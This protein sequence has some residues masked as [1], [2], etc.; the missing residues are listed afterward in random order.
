M[1]IFDLH[2]DLEVYF[3]I[4]EFLDMPIKDIK[5]LDLRRHGDIPQF[6]KS[7]L[8][9]AV[10]NIFPFVYQNTH[11]K[12]IDYKK[13]LKF[14]ENF[15]EWIFSY[16][17]F[18]PVLSKKDLLEINKEKD[19]IGIILGVEGLNFLD[20]VK[21][22]KDL[23]DLGIRCFGL[24]WNIDSI[25][26]TSLKT[27]KRFGLTPE[28]I[29]LIK[30]LEE[31]NVVIDLAHSSIFTIRDIFK[32]YPKPVIFSHNGVKKIVNFEQNLSTEIINKIRQK[33]GLIGLTLLPYSLSQN[34]QKLD[35]KRFK[36]QYDYLSKIISANIS[37][38]TDFFGFKFRDDFKGA[39]NYLEFSNSLKKIKVN[40]NFTFYNAFNFFKNTL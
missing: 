33:E 24:N 18:K 4:P 10:V 22:V 19:K 29:K 40:K 30:K 14:L 37:I 34:H 28:G 26:S 20:S 7:N 12:P 25:Y 6:K 2:L 39:R 1:K 35:I 3:R 16:K 13:F 17:I 11:W 36:Q 21:K 32:V 15:Q 23:Y 38:G 8:K 9:F 31:L 5:Y 27:E